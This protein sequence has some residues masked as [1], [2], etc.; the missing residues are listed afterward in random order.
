M[1]SR[2]GMFAALVATVLSGSATGAAA[3][4]PGPRSALAPPVF[5]TLSD[6]VPPPA[7]EALR[8]QLIE[9]IPGAPSFWVYTGATIGG[10]VGALAGGYVG[11]RMDDSGGEDP[12]L[13]GFIFGLPVGG[14]FGA[15]AGARIAAGDDGSF[16]DAMAGSVL[17]TLAGAGVGLAAGDPFS[18][19]A[20][21]VV[22]QVIGAAFAV[23]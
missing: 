21:A 8:R 16:G 18:A 3:Q 5:A 6:P 20:L 15:P 4:M 14:M 13:A 9:L 1:M 12:G 22:G 17:G 10:L 2:Y 11:A 7:E 23:D 19:A